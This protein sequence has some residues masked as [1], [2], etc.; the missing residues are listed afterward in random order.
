MRIE[1]IE[2]TK[3]LFNRN[4]SKII[5]IQIMTNIGS[6]FEA[7]DEYGAA[8]FIEHMF[9]KGTPARDAKRINHDADLMGAKL[10]AWT[11]HDQTNYYMS[12]MQ[13]NFEKGFE[14][15]SDI[16]LNATFPP[17]EMEKERTVILS[18]I[19]RYEDDPSSYISDL[20][21]D[22]FCKNRLAHKV[23]G[24][25]E[26]VSKITRKQLLDFKNRY[27]GG[28]NVLVSVVGD[29][30]YEKLRDAVLKYFKNPKK[31]DKPDGLKPGSYN[32]GF[33]KKTK[34]DIQ[35]AQYLL[36]YQALP[37]LHPR[38]PIQGIMSFVLGGNSSAFLFERI[39]EELGLCYGI[40]ARVN[41]FMGFNY[42][43]IS[44]G[45]AGKDLE[46]VHSETMG[47]I[48][49]MQ[50][51]LIDDER[52]EMIKASMLSGLYM[53]IESSS[54]LNSLLSLSYMKGE[55]GDIIAKRIREIKEATAKDIRESARETF[56]VTPLRAELH[57]S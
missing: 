39:R 5:N 45:A 30:D 57:A 25:I 53:G 11:W 28:R 27:Y 6:S 10:N 18:E 44:T 9:F 21:V 48:Q 12:V 55:D 23:T 31:C 26:S 47:I 43:E 20:A 36:L 49:K 32:S 52:L 3:V 14:L 4:G 37:Y 40:Y 54:G 1:E 19:R 22:H 46:L 33:Y 2:G 42:L 24:T 51:T 29:M 15:L 35:E 38:A 13:E 50:D 16:Y 41:R 8:H 7:P 34:T 17:D 56:C